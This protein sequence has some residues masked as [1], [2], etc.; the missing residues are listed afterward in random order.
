[1]LS[2]YEQM[3]TDASALADLYNIR[4]EQVT[5]VQAALP[6]AAKYQVHVSLGWVAGRLS[7][8]ARDHREDCDR[9][10]S[11]RTCAGLA[12]AI[13]VQLAGVRAC[14]DEQLRKMLTPR[15]CWQF[16]KPRPTN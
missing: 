4:D 11:C 14:H 8:I 16:W 5:E 12:E 3:L 1:M 15:R 2:P 6:G 10:D 9:R 7:G 13:T